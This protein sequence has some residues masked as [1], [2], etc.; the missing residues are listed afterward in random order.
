MRLGKLL[1]IAGLT[2]VVDSVVWG[3]AKA[4][5]MAV[6]LTGLCVILLLV[7]GLFDWAYYDD[8]FRL[9]LTLV[10]F[11][12]LAR[13]AALLMEGRAAVALAAIVFLLIV[14]GVF[15]PVV[16]GFLAGWDTPERRF[17]ERM[18]QACGY[19]YVYHSRTATAILT[20]ST[21]T[22]CWRPAIRSGMATRR[23]RSLLNWRKSGPAEGALENIRRLKEQAAA[24]VSAPSNSLPSWVWWI[25]VPAAIWWTIGRLFGSKTSADVDIESQIARYRR[26]GFAD[27][28]QKEIERR[29]RDYMSGRTTKF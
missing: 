8:T 26:P 27:P 23:R 29:M 5:Q 4:P 25:G 20:T 22:P 10:G 24:A 6:F 3:V 7:F 18:Q 15:E 1:A 17:T 13:V 2:Y 19:E 9:A 28:R 12:A 11:V 14:M 16:S 21:T